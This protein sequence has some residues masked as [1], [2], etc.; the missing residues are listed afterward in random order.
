MAAA[1]MAGAAT[2]PRVL[3]GRAAG[4]LY[5]GE[6][7]AQEALARGVAAYVDEGVS[8]A[9]FQTG[10]ARFDGEWAL[11]TQVMAVLGLGQVVIEHPELAERYLP[12][13]E[14]GAERL[15]SPATTAFGAEAWGIGALD[16]LD[17]DRGHAYLGYVD[18][19]LGMARLL[20][21]GAR[22]AEAHARIT[23]VLVRRLG[24]APFGLIETYPGEA[25]PADVAAALAAIELYPRRAPGVHRAVID[26]VAAAF[27]ERWVDPA[28]G[29][30]FQAGDARSGRPA[31]P[32]RASGT[33]LAAYF[34]SYADPALAR[35]IFAAVARTQ[36]ASLLGF[37]G[38]REYAPGQG[39]SGDIDSGPVIFGVSISATGFALAGAR[40]SGDRALFEKLYRTTELFGV[41]VERGRAR[42]F[43][44][45][46]PLGNALLLA[47]LTADRWP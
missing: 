32:P 4:A 24:R 22:V 18:L 15:L 9:S 31:G 44:T 35:Q 2:V 43:A 14:R 33:A 5:D 30:L 42:R 16:D 34:L 3:V 7:E 46:G 6:V 12:V 28:S 36:Q 8:V 26:K 13:I 11:V 1:V 29:L 23:A 17:D 39:G 45:G 20:G 40:A 21:A 41:P 38:I 19:G 47:M 25:Y 37:G 27:R 10:S